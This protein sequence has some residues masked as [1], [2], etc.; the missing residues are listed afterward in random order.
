MP[1]VEVPLAGF[2]SR[3]ESAATSLAT[4]SGNPGSQLSHGS[5]G[6]SA[7]TTKRVDGAA[8]PRPCTKVLLEGR[9]VVYVQDSEG[10]KEREM[11][12]T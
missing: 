9:C 2:A 5:R 11:Q 7:E 10:G 1:L 6:T 4:C 12:D 3:A 8:G